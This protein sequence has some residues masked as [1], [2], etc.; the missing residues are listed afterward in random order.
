VD[1][2]FDGTGSWPEPDD[3]S[4][5]PFFENRFGVQNAN[6]MF[7]GLPHTSIV[8]IMIRSAKSDTVVKSIA[9]EAKEAA[10]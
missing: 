8:A 1:Y 6:M 9:D 7:L 2:T 10:D 3:P 5:L 4:I